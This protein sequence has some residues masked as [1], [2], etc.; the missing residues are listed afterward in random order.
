MIKIVFM[1]KK[2]IFLLKIVKTFLNT[3]YR[4]F[5]GLMNHL[6]YTISCE[7]TCVH[8]LMCVCVGGRVG[9]CVCTRSKISYNLLLVIIVHVH[10]TPLPFHIVF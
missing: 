7:V 4:H 9:G 1:Q 8:S 3:K 5:N 2:N 10:C 6:L